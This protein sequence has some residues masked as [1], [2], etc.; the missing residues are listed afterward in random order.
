MEIM[1]HSKAKCIE[2]NVTHWVVSWL[3]GWLADCQEKKTC[4]FSRAFLKLTV[5]ALVT[6]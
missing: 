5:G 3:V 6:D 4:N 2:D 1:F